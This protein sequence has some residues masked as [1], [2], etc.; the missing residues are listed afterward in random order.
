MSRQL[1]PTQ[2]RL[3]GA[4]ALCLAL[5]AAPASSQQ[6]VAALDGREIML[7]VD[8]RPRGGDQVLTATWRLTKEKGRE[9]VRDTRSCWRDYRTEDGGIRSKRL[10]VF[11]SPADVRDMAFLVWSY[12]DPEADDAR[13]IHLPALLKTRRVAG[14]D[15]GKSFA[16]TEFNYE[17]LAD[18]GVDEE[19]HTLLRIE[20]RDGHTVYVVDSRP[21]D[22]DS[23]YARRL[24]YVDAST[25]VVPRIEYF[26]RHDRLERELSIDWQLVNGIWDWAR[27]DMQN[28][29]TGSRTTVEAKHV[30]HGVGLGD[31]NFSKHSMRCVGPSGVA[32]VGPR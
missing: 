9:R 7:K 22:K 13:W 5:A 19:Q 2:V 27:L 3:A 26:N 30:Q 14:R 23:G 15:R 31:E 16:G 17:D 4:A 24:Q 20:L 29:R 21:R 18:R 10:I 8:A 6:K 28:V 25:W 11:D 32:R 12:V 1:M